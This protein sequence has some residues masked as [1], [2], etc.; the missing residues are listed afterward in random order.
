MS[1]PS[2][3]DSFA[4]F[5][6]THTLQ[7]DSHAAQHNQEQTAIVAI[8]NKIGT[9]TSTPTSTSVLVGNGTGTSTWG[10][11]NLTNQVNGVL[12]TT[13]G[14]T[15]T[16]STTGTG[17]V[18]FGT[19]PTINTPNITY[20]NN[21]IPAVAIVNNSLTSNQLA[22]N[23]VTAPNIGTDSS[24]SWQSWTPTLVN[25]TL[26]NGTMVGAYSQVGKTVNARL[27]IT[28]GSTS[29]MGSIPTFTFPVTASLGSAVVNT[30]MN[31]SGISSDGASANFILTNVYVNSSTT[32]RFVVAGA[33]GAY[34]QFTNLGATVPITW[35]TGYFLQIAFSYEA[36]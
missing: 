22:N 15:G 18:V 5:T 4:G 28:F 25:L 33:S 3:T 13:N 14:G 1:F 34:A 27:L 6:S 10:T 9:G 7:Q 29:S 8:E 19:A 17:L 31:S 35:T 23:A 21:S 26:G 32:G 12:P 30:M 20:N 16:T 11:V 24:F 36:A 2:S